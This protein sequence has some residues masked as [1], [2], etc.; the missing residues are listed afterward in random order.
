M[1]NFYKE[2]STY[3]IYNNGAI[4][5]KILILG[6]T[7]AMGTSLVSILAKRNNDLFITSRKKRISQENNIKYIQGNAHDK[8]FFNRNIK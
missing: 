6:G 7:G 3:L 8:N 1:L 5:L 4:D 2:N